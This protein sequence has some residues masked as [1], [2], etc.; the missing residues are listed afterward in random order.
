MTTVGELAD[1]LEHFAPAAL[2]A[3][4]DNVGLLVGDRSQKVERVMT[5][6]TI[7][8]AV[9]AEAVQERVDLIV[10]HH[11]LPF[12]P[13]KRLTADEPTGRMLLDLIRSGVAVYSPHTAFDSAATGINQ[14][15]AEGL[16]LTA[17]EPLDAV[18]QA[19]RVGKLPK[20]QT[21]AQVAARLKQFLKI[22]GLHA[23]GDL[24]A[25]VTSVAVACGSAGEFLDLAIR[26]GCQL[27]VTGETRLHTCY[28]AESRGIALL[29]AGHYASERFGVERLAT[30]IA[31]QFPQL[32][33]WP[34]RREADPLSWI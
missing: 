6:L 28:D 22:N 25:P 31:E 26:R 3:E 33:I 24:Q 19:G 32:T 30:V 1:F 21:V 11:P 23:V 17:I 16:E 14:Q 4:W 9:A 7:T 15:L 13:L 20:P 34:S 10:T 18:A 2:A 5:C 27:L 8:P 29:L 12:R